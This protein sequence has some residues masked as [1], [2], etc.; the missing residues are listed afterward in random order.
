M[1]VSLND[2]NEMPYFDMESRNAVMGANSPIMYAESRSNRV[3]PL[4]ATEPDGDS[5]RW[6]VTGPDAPDFEIIDVQDIASD[7]KDRSGV[8]LQGSQ[9]DFEDGKGSGE[10]RRQRGR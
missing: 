6:E 9:P 3:A 10:L 7:G 8:A 4:A 1:T 2:L 5:L